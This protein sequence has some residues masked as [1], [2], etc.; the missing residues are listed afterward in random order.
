M[1]VTLAEI[2]DERGMIDVAT[3]ARIASRRGHHAQAS[4]RGVATNASYRQWRMGSARS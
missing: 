4:V 2:N 3:H 1:T